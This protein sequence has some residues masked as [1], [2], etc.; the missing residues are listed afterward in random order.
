MDELNA[1]FAQTPVAAT[2]L[3]AMLIV[4]AFGFARP[5]LITR[6]LFR[7][8][9][10]PRQGTFWSPAISAFLHADLMHLLFNAFTFWS[11]GFPLERTIGSPR[12]AALYAFGLLCSSVSTWVL[13]RADADYRSLGASG[14]ILA[15]LFAAI[16]YAPTSSLFILPIP[17]PIP[18]P[19]F[20]VL[21]LMFSVYASRRA[22]GHVAHDAHVAGALAGV[23][24]VALT[25]WPAVGRAV[26]TVFD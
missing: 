13:H 18:A 2:L 16:L 3:A 22:T 4:S 11:F 1:A 8:S 7:P 15:V 21:Y 17:V 25:D 19:L 26:A 12:F 10:W 6:F 24:F 5:A 23:V 14:A 9:V 20:A